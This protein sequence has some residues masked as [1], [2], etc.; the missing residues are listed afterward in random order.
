MRGRAAR[1]ERH[2]HFNIIVELAK[3]CDQAVK[4]E[5]GMTSLASCLD[6]SY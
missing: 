6:Y 5:T 4:R 2:L 1:F 3:D